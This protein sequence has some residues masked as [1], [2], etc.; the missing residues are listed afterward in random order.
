MEGT[1]GMKAKTLIACLLTGL[2]TFGQQGQ[3]ATKRAA[4]LPQ[5]TSFAHRIGAHEGH[6][7]ATLFERDVS[8]VIP[9]AIRG[10][11]PLQMLNPRAPAQYGTAEE[12]IS[13]DPTVPGKGDGIK[14]LSISF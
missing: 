8:G 2:L 4:A 3:A 11:D 12:N 10:G 1:L 7:P 14:L 5:T 13:L 6:R 9:R